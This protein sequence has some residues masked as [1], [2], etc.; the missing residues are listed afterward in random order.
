M[1]N[2]SPP[3]YVRTSSH[4]TRSA[5]LH[6]LEKVFEHT[7][8]PDVFLRDEVSRR[9]GLSEAKVQVWFQNRRCALIRLR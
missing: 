3:P 6:A 7:H 1:Y 8:Y 4:L 5:Q 9:I 2:F